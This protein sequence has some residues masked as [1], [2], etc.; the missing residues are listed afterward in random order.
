MAKENVDLVSVIIPS[1]NR[2]ERLAGAIESVMKQSWSNIEV[3]VVDDASTDDTP[4]YLAGLLNDGGIL[5]KVVRNEIAQGGSGARN[6]GIALAQGQYVAFLDD[7]DVWLP[8]KLT[9]Q[10]GMMKANPS[11][12][13]ASCS[14]WVQHSSGKRALKHVVM[15]RE[16]QQILH[17]NHLGGA[18]MCLTTRQMLIDIGGFDATLRSGQDWDLWIRL[19]DR[20]R[21]VV[22]ADPLVSYIYHQGVSIT[23][24]LMSKYLGTRRL[25]FKY[26]IR[27][28]DVTRKHHLN[29]LIFYKKVLNP[30]QWMSLPHE[31]LGLFSSTGL[32]V[33]IRYVYR[34]LKIRH[35]AYRTATN[36]IP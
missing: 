3:I 27:M 28:T 13:A 22:C 34:Y 19:N 17:T 2:C 32:N 29:E 21:V 14:F 8:E 15:P 7:D 33:G 6:Q 5:L 31:L 12:S 20:G 36:R 11:A 4:Q 9:R 25:Y 16:S 35:N 26:R 1:R 24:N 23:G 18:S 10:I 30:H